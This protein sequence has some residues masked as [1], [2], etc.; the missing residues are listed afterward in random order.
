MWNINHFYDCFPME[1]MLYCCFLCALQSMA[2][3]FRFNRATH[4]ILISLCWQF[5]EPARG[6]RSSCSP[7]SIFQGWFAKIL[8]FPARHGVTL[9]WLVSFMENAIYKWMIW[10]SSCFRKPPDSIDTENI[11]EQ[12]KMVMSNEEYDLF[13]L[14]RCFW[15]KFKG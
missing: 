2:Y 7:C 10:K 1:T 8:G 4:L 9:K 6:E 13:R 11:W 5:R 12:W 14:Q 3:M 15:S